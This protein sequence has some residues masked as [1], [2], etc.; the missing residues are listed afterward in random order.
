MRAEH[1]AKILHRRIARQ[2]FVD[3]SERIGDRLAK[4]PEDDLHPRMNVEKAAEYEAHRLRPRLEGKAPG[5][6]DEHRMR[7]GIVAIIRLD[8]RGVRIRGMDVQRHI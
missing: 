1:L 2:G 6:A 8:N 5:G 4:M 7:L 3:A